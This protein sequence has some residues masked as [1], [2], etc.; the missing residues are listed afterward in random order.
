M[1]LF[2]QYGDVFNI[3]I[4]TR[5]A[6]DEHILDDP[7]HWMV[8]TNPLDFCALLYTNGNQKA[9]NEVGLFF[10]AKFNPNNVMCL[11]YDPS[12]EQNPFVTFLLFFDRVHSILQ[13]A[14]VSVN[15]VI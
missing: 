3:A 15:S 10:G 11:R 4:S 7:L 14:S 8:L 1:E 2:K 13:S 6:S 12:I 9:A 5:S